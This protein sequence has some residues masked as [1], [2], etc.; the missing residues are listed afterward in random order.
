MSPTPA[1]LSVAQRKA[2]DPDPRVP[3]GLHP[4]PTGTGA[5]PPLATA[6]PPGPGH[7][8]PLRGPFLHGVHS[9][10][11]QG[12]LERRGR[13]SHPCSS[14]LS[15]EWPAGPCSPPPSP[16]C[17]RPART[18]AGP[19][20]SDAPGHSGALRLL[21]PPPGPPPPPPRGP[22]TSALTTW[23]A[24]DLLASRLSQRAFIALAQC[25]ERPLA[26]SRLPP[27]CNTPW[28]SAAPGCAGKGG[29]RLPCGRGR[30]HLGAPPGVPTPASPL[31]G[32]G[33][34]VPFILEAVGELLSTRSRSSFRLWF[35]SVSSWTL[36]DKLRR[37]LLIFFCLLRPIFFSAGGLGGMR[38]SG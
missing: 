24:C 33:E 16:L 9:A 6:V 38:P 2:A 35:S 21:V 31:G 19:P 13:P 17:P 12:V 36:W 11:E 34:Q 23:P 1:C 20:A 28:S 25:L 8:R 32:S 14:P 18:Q 15:P 7:Q 29:P 27:L 10:Q 22:L 3:H 26:L 30:P 4:L 37:A 5:W